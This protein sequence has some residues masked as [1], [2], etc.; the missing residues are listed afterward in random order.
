MDRHVYDNVG[1]NVGHHVYENVRE[2]R[3]AT[4]DLILAVKPKVAVEEQQVTNQDTHAHLC[5]FSSGSFPL[6][7]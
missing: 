7:S 2:L 6:L 4:P 1:M 3:D 5:S